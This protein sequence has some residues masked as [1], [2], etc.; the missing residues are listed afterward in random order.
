[1]FVG[2]EVGPGSLECGLQFRLNDWTYTTI[3]INLGVT[4]SLQVTMLLFCLGSLEVFGGL[5]AI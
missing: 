1:M 3:D 4:Y 2:S 5:S